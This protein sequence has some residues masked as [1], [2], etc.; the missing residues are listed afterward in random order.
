MLPHSAG[1]LPL[2]L[3]VSCT[4]LN[5]LYN[6]HGVTAEAGV[7]ETIVTSAGGEAITLAT[8]G[9]GVLTTFAGSVY[10]AATGNLAASV[11][12]PSG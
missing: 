5:G 6:S 4:L 10:T 12:T 2:A 8:S 1:Q 11:S 7:L 3:L 9:A